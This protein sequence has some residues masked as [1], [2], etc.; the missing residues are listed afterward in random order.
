MHAASHRETHLLPLSSD[1]LRPITLCWELTQTEN[2]ERW[3][4][5]GS[6][7]MIVFLVSASDLESYFIPVKPRSNQEGER[8]LQ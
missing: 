4:G 6:W 8:I 1:Q 5:V 2:L 3:K 7:K